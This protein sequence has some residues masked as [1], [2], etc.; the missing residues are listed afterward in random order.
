ML[1]LDQTKQIA[2]NLN[3]VA[4]LYIERKTFSIKAALNRTGEDGNIQ[5]IT[6]GTYMSFENC[7]MVLEELMSRSDEYVWTDMPLGGDVQKWLDDNDAE[8]T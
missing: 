6:L 4:Y 1:I 5:K 8:E 7:R 2:I 3:N